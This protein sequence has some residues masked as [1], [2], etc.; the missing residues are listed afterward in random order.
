MIRKTVVSVYFLLTL[1]VEQMFPLEG[2]YKQSRHD[3]SLSRSMVNMYVKRILNLYCESVVVVSVAASV[4]R[5]N[6]LGR[7]RFAFMIERPYPLFFSE[8]S[9]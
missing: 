8:T 4:I 9:T 3:E 7:I 5:Q 1:A 2:N 6:R